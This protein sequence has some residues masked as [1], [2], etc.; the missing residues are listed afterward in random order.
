M[1]GPDAATSTRATDRRGVDA[2]SRETGKRGLEKPAPD[3]PPT[4]PQKPPVKETQINVW[5]FRIGAFLADS[6]SEW[7]H[8]IHIEGLKDLLEKLA[9]AEL[10][11]RVSKLVIVAHGDSAG[12][13]Q[14]DHDVTAK[15]V[16][17]FADDF[18]KLATFLKP[19]GKLMFESCQAGLGDEGTLLLKGISSHLQPAQTVVGFMVNGL[20]GRI[21]MAGDVFEAPNSMRDMPATE[22]KGAQ[23]MTEESL[24]AKWAQNGRILRLPLPEE[25]SGL[26]GG[27]LVTQSL[28]NGKNA[29]PLEG[30]TAKITLEEIALT[31]GK[32]PVWSGTHK[33]DLITRPRTIDI[34]FA[35]GKEKGKTALGILRFGE[36]DFDSLTICLA[37]PG[38]AR[39]DD[40]T[41]LEK[42]GRTLLALKRAPVST[43]KRKP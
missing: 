3:L 23:R 6:K 8:V 4:P 9:E 26:R 2:G 18:K 29:K 25:L 41:S 16:A 33:L 32:K 19:D 14:L 12:L 31:K 21:G 17:S 1:A 40:F 15:N 39:P 10:R 20:L 35:S 42:S 28:V 38:K 5:A 37:E 27:W 13:I 7:T 11:G 22:F 34:T 24:Y 43:D 36:A 30:A